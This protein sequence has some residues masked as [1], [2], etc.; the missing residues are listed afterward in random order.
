MKICFVT[1]IFTN[2]V[3]NTDQPTYFE[4]DDKFDYFLFTNQEPSVYKT[5]WSV[6]QLT[7]LNFL[8]NV[9]NSRYPK[10][11]IWDYFAKQNV[12]YDFIFECDA[13]L[14]PK[15]GMDWEKYASNVINSSNKFKFIQ[16][17]HRDKH[18]KGILYECQAIVKVNKDTETNML[19]TYNYL[20]KLNDLYQVNVD[21]Y[22]PLFFE[23]TVFGYDPNNETT[24]SVLRE[25][26]EL[27]TSVENPT[28]R[29][30]P[31]WNFVL[32]KN[33]LQPVV[34]TPFRIEDMGW[35]RYISRIYTN[36]G[37]SNRKI[38]K[39]NSNSMM[40]EILFKQNVR[41]IGTTTN[42]YHT[43][44]NSDLLNNLGSK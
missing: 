15:K 40:F 43:N 41:H 42:F 28:Y 34:F 2:N 21:F 23:N 11:M 29:D 14:I 31:L 10:F 9:V 32:L 17:V 7:D 16:S 35:Q 39:D 36:V 38:C 25:F 44:L 6:V 18:H 1:A 4:K 24:Q 12:K 37:V 33:N 19:A 26:W 27:Y 13:H 3:N 20:K 22:N 30:Q 5:S 8:N